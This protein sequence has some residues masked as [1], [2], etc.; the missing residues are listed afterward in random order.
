MTFRRSCSI[1]SGD[2]LSSSSAIRRSRSASR[3]QRR[4]H[5]SSS[6]ASRAASLV[7]AL[8]CIAGA[9]PD[10]PWS[11]GAL[12]ECSTSATSATTLIAAR[13]LGSVFVTVFA[14]QL[15]LRLRPRPA[16]FVRRAPPLR[17]PPFRPPLRLE[18]LLPFLPRPEP[19]FL[20][21]PDSLF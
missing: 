21:P 10:D 20:P 8:L 2:L 13:V 4:R 5:S 3:S 15:L 14:V 12:I 19:L 18:V 7:F 16:D 1:F 9:T 17:V 6:D 11:S